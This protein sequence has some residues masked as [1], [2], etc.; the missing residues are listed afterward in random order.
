MKF[1]TIILALATIAT[2]TQAASLRRRV[3]RASVEVEH[4]NKLEGVSGFLDNDMDTK[5]FADET[6]RFLQMS[7]SVTGPTNA[8][9]VDVLGPLV[10]AK[11]SVSKD[12]RSRDILSILTP[13]SEEMDSLLIANTVQYQARMFVDE[14]DPALLCAS[15]SDRIQQRY[16][17]A[18]VY[19]SMGGSSWTTSTNWMT[20]AHE[21][22][23]FGFEC[24]GYTAGS[25]AYVPISAIRLDENGLSGE[26]PYELFGLPSLQ[27]LVM[28]GNSVSGSIP[29]GI[30]QATQLATLDLDFNSLTGAL[31]DALYS[32]PAITN[33]DLNNNNLSGELSPSISGL[34]T[35]NVLNLE[36]N[37]FSGEIPILSVL[38]LEQ[39]A[40]FSIQN[41]GFTGTLDPICN[42]LDDRRQTFP[43]Y[44]GFLFADCGGT[45]PP[46]VCSCCT[47]LA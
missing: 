46:V 26:L 23:W 15:D 33:I 45:S 8:P 9:S 4:S 7:M 39:L 28:E 3:R 19:Y 43:N 36:D 13:L 31:P 24:D 17:A 12:E 11:C 20:E 44:A 30:S 22:E 6:L 47:C 34:T 25:E 5:F 32:L 42:V 29:E 35:L 16:R 2:S 27:R 38:Q 14:T 18:I 41:N 40:A 21:C 1:A 37:N 10:E